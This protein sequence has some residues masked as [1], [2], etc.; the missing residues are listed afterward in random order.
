MLDNSTITASE[1]QLMNDNIALEVG[2]AFTFAEASPLP[3]ADSAYTGLY[4]GQS[5]VSPAPQSEGE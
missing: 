2:E 1:L 3:L 4:S 5:S